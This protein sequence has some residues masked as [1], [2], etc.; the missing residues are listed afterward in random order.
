M[1][2]TSIRPNYLVAPKRSDVSISNHQRNHG[3]HSRVKPR[4]AAR[5]CGPACRSAMAAGMALFA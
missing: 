4:Q 1:L 3:T 5:S 2:I